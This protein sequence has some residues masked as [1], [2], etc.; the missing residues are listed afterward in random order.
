MFGVFLWIIFIIGVIGII[1]FCI[2]EKNTINY[3]ETLNTVIS[4]ICGLLIVFSIVGGLVYTSNIEFY[5]SPENYYETLLQK[6]EIISKLETYNEEI[7][8]VLSGDVAIIDFTKQE[9]LIE[10]NSQIEKYNYKI[11]KHRKYKESFWFSKLYNKE[12][13]NLELFAPIFNVQEE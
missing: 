4:V 6:Q 5:T 2:W 7:H 13:A 11:I 10:L 12:V 3:N 1:G 8:N 9:E